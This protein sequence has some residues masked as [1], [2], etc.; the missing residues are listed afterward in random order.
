MAT[1][2]ELKTFGDTAAKSG[3]ITG[4]QVN[5]NGQA[6]QMTGYNIGG[7]EYFKLRDLAKAI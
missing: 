4:T 5:L 2:S 1:G 3:V 6:V 7:S